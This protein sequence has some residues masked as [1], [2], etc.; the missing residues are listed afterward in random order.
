M[1]EKK[2][3]DILVVG[4]GGQG[5]V[6]AGEII[7]SV[8]LAAGHDVKQSEVHGMAQRGGSVTSHVRFGAEVYSPAIE[9]GYADILLSFEML[10]G[11]RWIDYLHSNGVAL[12]NDHRIVPLTVT[13]GIAEYPTNVQKQ[14]IAR[15]GHF[16]LVDG[17]AIACKVGNAR[18]V[19]VALLGALSTRLEFDRRLWEKAIRQSVPRN[20][21]DINLA[22]FHLG[23]ERGLTGSALG[24]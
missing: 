24:A 1:R 20:T 12:I 17:I 15:C 7:A 5:V 14:I 13:S 23:R 6:V 19:N 22:G 18:V 9:R 3:T 11:L 4:V 10:E 16:V 21:I 8:C 2:T